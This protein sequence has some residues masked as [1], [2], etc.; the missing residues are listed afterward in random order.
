MA[1]QTLAPDDLLYTLPRPD[2]AWFLRPDGHQADRS[3]HGVDH[4]RRVGVHALELAAVLGATPRE[5]EALRLAALWHDI[6][7]ECD[8]QDYFHGARS[9]GKVAGLGLHRG[10]EPAV[11]E[12]ALFAITYHVPPDGQAE[13]A[14]REQ[15]EPRSAL[16]V[17]RILKDADALDRVRFGPMNLKQGMLRFPESLGRVDRAFALAR[18]TDQESR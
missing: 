2:P 13:P 16:K 18:A 10:V 6:G 15:A 3:I 9:A 7:R 1:A 5:R 12:L 14:A 4:A 8:G 11:L 17:L